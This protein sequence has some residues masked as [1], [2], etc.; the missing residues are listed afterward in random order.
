MKDDGK[1]SVN[2]KN[3]FFEALEKHQVRICFDTFCTDVLLKRFLSFYTLALAAVNKLAL[4]N[5][6][7]VMPC[8]LK[9]FK[10]FQCK[11]SSHI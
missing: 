1:K 7:K 4:F 8:G 2:I 6:N 11:L 10:Y 3:S 9:L 5:C